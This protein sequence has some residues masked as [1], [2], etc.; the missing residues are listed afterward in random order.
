MNKQEELLYAEMTLLAIKCRGAFINDICHLEKLI[1]ETISR[2]FC[3]TNEKRG[4]LLEIVLGNEKIN[5]SN[6]VVTLKLLFEKQNPSIYVENPKMFNEITALIEQRNVLA[7]YMLDTTSEAFDKYKK[8]YI[9][10]VKFKHNT[11]TIWYTY[12]ELIHKVEEIN[13]HVLA[14]RNFLSSWNVL[15]Y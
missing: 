12:E 7:H 10:F 6:K 14:F 4:E 11:K 5:F 8:D 15:P 2:Y 3:D 9:G 13:K 1:D